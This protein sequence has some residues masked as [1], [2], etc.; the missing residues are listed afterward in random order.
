MS[1]VEN[2]ESNG[3]EVKKV[4]HFP[5]VFILSNHSKTA[6]YVYLNLLYY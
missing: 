1:R 4:Q 5:F 3:H 6:V 2:V